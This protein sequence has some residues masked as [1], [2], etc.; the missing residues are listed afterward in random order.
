MKHAEKIWLLL[1]GLTLAGALLAEKG[2]SGW[3]LTLIVAFLIAFKGGIVID[4]YMDMRSANTRIRNVLR[5]F[6]TLVP[7][8]VILSHGWGEVIRRLTTIS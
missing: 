4:Y 1:I 6:I 8:L 5:V 2:Q 7:V 3:F